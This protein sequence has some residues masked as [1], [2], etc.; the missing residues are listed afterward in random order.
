[1]DAC[2]V[3]NFEELLEVAVLHEPRFMAQRCLGAERRIRKT[4][5]VLG[6]ETTLVRQLERIQHI[7]RR[8]WAER[9]R[10]AVG[11]RA[12]AGVAA[13]AAASAGGRAANN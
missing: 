8:T 10:K 13:A 9:R 5:K 4:K 1:M 7:L 12:A 6:V 3:A 2:Q 11:H